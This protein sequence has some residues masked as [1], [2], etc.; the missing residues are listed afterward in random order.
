LEI[1]VKIFIALLALCFT[2]SAFAGNAVEGRW[3]FYKK[4][5]QENEM[6]E[7]PGATLRMF[8]EYSANGESHLFWWHEGDTDH[9]SRRGRYHIESGHIVEEVIWVDPENT[10]ACGQD[11]DMQLGRKTRTPYYFHGKDLAL[12]FHLGDEPLDLIWRKERK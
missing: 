9:C 5:F 7:P 2:T 11:P 3:R 10:F 1:A 8:F 6:P 12:R 4:I